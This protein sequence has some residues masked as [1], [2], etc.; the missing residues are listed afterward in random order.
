MY[1]ACSYEAMPIG[2]H[3]TKQTRVTGMGETGNAYTVLVDKSEAKIPLGKPWNRW[4]T[5]MDLEKIT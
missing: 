1:I 3:S 4:N 2:K 5:E